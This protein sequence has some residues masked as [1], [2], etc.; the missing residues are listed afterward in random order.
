MP[1]GL[2]SAGKFIEA[3]TVALRDAD[4]TWRRIGEPTAELLRGE[5]AAT[6]GEVDTLHVN[7]IRQRLDKYL[8]K[9]TP[10]RANSIE[11]DHGVGL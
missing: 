11:L 2:T 8:A 3:L 10:A 4:Q 7:S 1:G 5:I 9:P 6:R